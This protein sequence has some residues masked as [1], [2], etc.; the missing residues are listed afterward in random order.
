MS[1]VLS[2]KLDC[3]KCTSEMQIG[4]FIVVCMLPSAR[5]CQTKQYLVVEQRVIYTVSFKKGYKHLLQCEYYLH[6]IITNS[7]LL[8]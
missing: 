5:H 2:T 8:K 4:H 1:Y 3:P 6:N 7:K